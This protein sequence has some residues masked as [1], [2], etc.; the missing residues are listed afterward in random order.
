MYDLA[1]RA[2]L[3]T[4]AAGNIGAAMARLFGAAGAR[5]VLTDIAPGGAEGLAAQLRDQGNE[6]I[7]A[8]HDVG[9]E[10]DWERVIALATGRWQRLDVLINNAAIS[11][12]RTTF[13]ETRLDDWRRVMAVNCDGAFL[14]IKHAIPAMLRGSGG[15]IVNIASI[16][17]KVGMPSLGSYCASK[18]AITAMTKA[19]AVECGA[20]QPRI[21]VNVVHPGQVDSDKFATGRTEAEKRRLIDSYPLGRIARPEEIAS[22]ALFLASD[23]SSFMTGAELVVD[24]GYLAS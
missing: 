4:G 1:Q 7:G 13:A 2:C 18:G 24:G 8:D 20:L 16:A 9:E 12:S 23:A 17:A 5:L 19:A 21:R 3:I 6:A 11:D 15:S 22:A 14:G 10:R